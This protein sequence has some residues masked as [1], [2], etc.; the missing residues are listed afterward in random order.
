MNEDVD[1]W[2]HRSRQ[3]FD[4][5]KPSK[6]TT[7]DCLECRDHEILLSANDLDTIKQ[8][9]CGGS[10]LTAIRF[11]SVQG[12][13]YYMPALVRTCL[14][15]IGQGVFLEEFLRF[16]DPPPNKQKTLLEQCNQEQREFVA[17]LLSTLIETCSGEVDRDGQSDEILICFE[18]WGLV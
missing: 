13:L 5:P 10:G 1:E 3:V 9:V 17:E 7:C 8:E 18:K 4:Q 12:Q 16:L 15:T 11:S 2:Y 14:Q 6:F